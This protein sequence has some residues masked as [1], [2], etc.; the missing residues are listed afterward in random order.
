MNDLIVKIAGVT[1]RQI[2]EMNAVWDGTGV[3]VLDEIDIAVD[4]A[5]DDGLITPIV[6][7][8]ANLDVSQISFVLKV[9]TSIKLVEIIEGLQ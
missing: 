2:P 7:D 6:R 9:K 3:K 4:V 5:T 8:A 1:L